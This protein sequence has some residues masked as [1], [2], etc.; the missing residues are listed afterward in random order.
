MECY[1]QVIKRAK[2][3]Y[4]QIHWLIGLGTYIAMILCLFAYAQLKHRKS[5]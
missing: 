2:N 5:S 3:T 1:N 4:T